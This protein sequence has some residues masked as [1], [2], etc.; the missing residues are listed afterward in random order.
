[1]TLRRLG[2][3]ARHEL[4]QLNFPP[5]N[6]VL[7]G[8]GPGGRPLLDV[9]VVG[10]GMCGQLATFALLR[11]GIRNLRCVDRAPRGLEGPWATFARMPILRSPKHLTVPDLGVASLSYRAWHEAQYG[12]RHW[13]RLHKI[14][15][16]D[17]RD[18]LLWVRETARIPVENG[19]EVTSLNLRRGFV[20]ASL[21]KRR[22]HARKVVLALG[23]EGSGALRWP[24]FR[25][26]DPAKRGTGVYHSADAIDFRTLRGKR[27]GILGAGSSAFDNAG[28]AL[29]AGAAEVTMFARRPQLPQVNKSKWTAFAGFQHGY[30][31][32]DDARRWRFYTYIFGEQVPPPYESILRCERFKGFRLRFSEGWDDILPGPEIKTHKGKFEF[33][34]VIVCT[35]F[36]VNLLERPEIASFR[37]TIETWRSH[38]SKAEARRFPEEA[39]FPYLGD[40]FQLRGRDPA[41]GRVHVF[42]WGS[43]M[44]HGAL[45]GDIPGIQIGANRLAQGIARDLFLENADAHYQRLLVHNEDELK[46]TKYFVS[47]SSRRPA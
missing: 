6:W 3:L 28:E 29:E 9:L 15:R 42:N 18:Y 25:T 36:D 19:V 23:R 30:F 4:S 26:F 17:W 31:P 12:A 11:E 46:P 41:L 34:A 13:R 21:G 14:A 2:R 40:A 43:T 44:S 32:L 27:V 22:L 33:D 5:A 45:A 20:Q 1:M 47:R 38:V 24:A 7:P 35:G 16:L 37:G 10:G 39:R 8:K